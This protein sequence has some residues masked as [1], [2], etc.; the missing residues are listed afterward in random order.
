M[1]ILLSVLVCLTPGDA[2]KLCDFAEQQVLEALTQRSPQ[3]FA[4]EV[5]FTKEGWNET[6]QENEDP[7]FKQEWRI[8]TDGMGQ[9]RAEVHWPQTEQKSRWVAVES[10]SMRW[11]CG[12]HSQLVVIDKIDPPKIPNDLNSEVYQMD[13][14]LRQGH[15]ELKWICPQH[16]AP[17][18]AVEIVVLDR[19]NLSAFVRVDQQPRA[20]KFRNLNGVHL[21]SSVTKNSH[22]TTGIWEYIDYQRVGE[23]WV[24]STM[25]YRE[26]DARGQT[27]RFRYSKIELRE[28]DSVKE[29]REFFRIPDP[30]DDLLRL[31]HIV[32]TLSNRFVDKPVAYEMTRVSPRLSSL[33]AGQ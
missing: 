20:Y 7:Y 19:D 28:T 32:W 10:S 11:T 25:E 9:L 23:K 26:I 17:G 12:L 29:L 3:G 8:C 30:D 31:T 6:S 15:A 4:G 21:V 1:P 27:H 14:Q 22:G 18:Q 16:V 2:G 5:L 33:R 24:P 13:C